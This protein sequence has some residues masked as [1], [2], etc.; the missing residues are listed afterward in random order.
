MS[1]DIDSHTRQQLA[2]QEEARRLQ[3]A[4]DQDLLKQRII[5]DQKVLTNFASVLIT[6]Y[7]PH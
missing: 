7:I 4:I 6:V 2:E 3:Q 5:Q 1:R